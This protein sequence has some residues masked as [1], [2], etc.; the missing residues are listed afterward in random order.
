[1]PKKI[2][3]LVNSGDYRKDGTDQVFKTKKEAVSMSA[4]LRALRANVWVEERE[5][6]E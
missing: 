6:T 1:M 5:A 3:V 2:Y 4:N